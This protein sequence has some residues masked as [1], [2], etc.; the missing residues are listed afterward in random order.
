LDERGQKRTARC[1]RKLRNAGA[2][3]EEKMNE[4]E[5]NQEMNQEKDVEVMEFELCVEEIDELIAKLHLLKESRESMSFE[6]D[7]DNELLINYS[8]GEENEGN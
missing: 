5:M 8:E 1:T 2:K 7:D 6:V 4:E 3:M